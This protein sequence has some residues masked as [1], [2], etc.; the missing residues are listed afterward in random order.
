[1][2]LSKSQRE[3]LIVWITEGIS[4]SEINARAAA[5]EPPFEISK[6]QADWYRKTRRAPIREIQS[7]DEFNALATGL[8]LKVKRVERLAALAALLEND[9]FGAR[10]WVE[11]VKGV[12]K[13]EDF[14]LIRYEEFN[15]AEVQQYRGLLDDIAKELGDRANKQVLSGPDDGPI[16][17]DNVVIYIPDNGRQ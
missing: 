6:Q 4:L 13:G 3:S 15:A 16:Q 1:M 14:Q 10:L 17:V 5:H 8:A 11:M 9:I 2:R 7:R 12:G